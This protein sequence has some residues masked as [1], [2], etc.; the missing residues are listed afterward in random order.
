MRRVAFVAGFIA[1][2]GMSGTALAD[3]YRGGPAY[4]P[5][6]SWS[7]VY[8]GSHL[9]GGW[10]ETS[11]SESFFIV[12]PGSTPLTQSYTA[13]GWLAGVHL[14]AMKQFGAF[15]TGVELN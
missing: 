2:L 9:G 1:L 12:G 3:G 11:L 15:V 6:Y 7:G 10:A 5:A 8:F 4:A 13:S 14:G